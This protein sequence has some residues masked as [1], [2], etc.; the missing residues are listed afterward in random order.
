MTITSRLHLLACG[1]GVFSYEI[2]G[3]KDGLVEAIQ[4][5]YSNTT[6]TCSTHNTES[7]E[8][9]SWQ[10][11]IFHR[12]CYIAAPCDPSDSDEESGRTLIKKSF[13]RETSVQQAWASEFT[14]C[15]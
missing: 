10:E 7:P 13:G 2:V 12:L 14:S 8:L 15:L 5:L 11:G 1:G 4:R 3:E 6:V 9:M